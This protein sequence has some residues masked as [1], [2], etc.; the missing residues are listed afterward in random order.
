MA[1]TWSQL[2]DEASST[3]VPAPL[4][5]PALAAFG[6]NLTDS[7]EDAISRAL[8]G[9]VEEVV[10]VQEPLDSRLM[11]A[12]ED[13]LAHT[14]QMDLLRYEAEER[15]KSAMLKGYSDGAARQIKKRQLPDAAVP[16][17]ATPA[18]PA[19]QN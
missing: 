12:L 5:I 19:T 8:E 11:T 3:D 6:Q 17:T 9:A 15:L 14:R 16:A 10:E 4:T 7:I 18:T 1:K 2:L 13:H